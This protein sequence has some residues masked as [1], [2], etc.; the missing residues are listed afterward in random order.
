MAVGNY[1]TTA[2]PTTLAGLVMQSETRVRVGTS[3][4]YDS[5][6]RTSAL[7]A[8]H[9]ASIGVVAGNSFDL[10]ELSTLGFEHVPT[11]EQPDTANVLQSS[12]QVL[13]DEETTITTGVQQFDQRVLELAVGTGVLYDIANEALI[14]V[15]G[16]CNTARRPLELS[17][18]NIGCNAPAAPV[19]TLVGI[20]A[21]IITVYDAQATS[22]LP[23]SDI[24]AG[25]INTLDI[26]WTAYPV[27]ARALGNKIFN[28]YL[29]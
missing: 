24:V 13:S 10:G 2:S 28:I 4:L 7:Y 19:D 25:E 17:A 27:P 29:F 18:T 23:W 8:A 16:Q 5:L 9:N 1:F 26:E 21:I 22:G 3:R 15:G 20:T 11:F 12:L 6:E 14:T